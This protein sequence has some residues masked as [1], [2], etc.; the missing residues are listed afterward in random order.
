MP[1]PCLALWEIAEVTPERATQ[2]EIVIQSKAAGPKDVRVELQFKIAGELKDL[3]RF[4]LR[5]G[6]PNAY[7]VT[8]ALKGDR[9]KPGGAIIGRRGVRGEDEGLCGVGAG[10]VSSVATG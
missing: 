1:T 10:R 5:V 2:L 9:S 3:D 7:I 4:D 6:E 8:A